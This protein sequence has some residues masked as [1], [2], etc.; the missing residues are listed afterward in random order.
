MRKMINFGAVA[1]VVLAASIQFGLP[2]QASMVDDPCY[3]KVDVNGV[4][5]YGVSTPASDDPNTS[6]LITMSENDPAVGPTSIDSTRLID[7]EKMIREDDFLRL[8]EIEDS[9]EAFVSA[10]LPEIVPEGTP[11]DQIP[12]KAAEWEASH[13]S[14]DYND[15]YNRDYQN[16]SHGLL[17][18]KGICATYATAFNTLVQSTP[19][20]PATGLVSYTCPDPVHYETRFVYSDLHAWS[21]ITCDGGKNWRFCDVTFYDGDGVHYQPQYLDMGEKEMNDGHHSN[22]YPFQ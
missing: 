21:A 16:A 10:N 11:M 13:M 2:V 1:A 5:Y 3:K 18:G 9:C 17:E 8:S 14:Y 6:L 19:I 15:M 12:T 7:G 22:Y 4:T 20:D